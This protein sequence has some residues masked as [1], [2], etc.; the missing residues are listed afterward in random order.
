MSRIADELYFAPKLRFA[1]LDWTGARLP[2][3]FYQRISG[4]Y[5]EPAV[6][7]ARANHAFAAGV[8]VVCAIDALALLITGSS[9]VRG[10]IIAFCRTIPDLAS[11]QNANMFC[12]HFRNGLVHE[13]RVKKGSEFSVDIRRVAVSDHA[14][15]VVNPLFLAQSVSGRLKEYVEALHRD[16][17]A[18]N[19]FRKKL[20]RKFRYELQH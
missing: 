4:F 1:E 13:S 5:L 18:K 17:A 12:E 16:P 2:T 8:L 20:K 14:R 10:R 9:S 15:L 11:D 6:A 7:L 3:Q 19:A